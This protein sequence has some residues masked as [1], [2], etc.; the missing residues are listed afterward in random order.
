MKRKESKIPLVLTVLVLAYFVFW[1]IGFVNRNRPVQPIQAEAKAPERVAPTPT[2]QPV[3]VQ[4]PLAMPPPA[5]T[6]EVAEKPKVKPSEEL[7]EHDPS[8]DGSAVIGGKVI[9]NRKIV[10][11]VRDATAKH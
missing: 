1:A 2:P 11:L 4:Q 6:P 10:A 8:S 9:T 7:S 3:V 5:P